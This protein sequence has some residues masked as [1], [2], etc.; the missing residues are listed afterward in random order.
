[1]HEISDLHESA[2]CK[3]RVCNRMSGL[4][5]MGCK[6][7]AAKYFPLV[8]ASYV[9]VQALLGRLSSEIDGVLG[10]AAEWSCRTHVPLGGVVKGWFRWSEKEQRGVAFDREVR[11]RCVVAGAGVDESIQWSCDVVVPLISGRKRT[12]RK[13]LRNVH[14]YVARHPV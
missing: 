3:V 14:P 7:A 8:A 2:L 5:E 4:R 11:A 6:P 10:G 13:K 9:E 12:D 1:V